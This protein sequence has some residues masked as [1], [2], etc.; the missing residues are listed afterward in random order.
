MVMVMGADYPIVKQ[1][2]LAGS[3]GAMRLPAS[4]WQVGWGTRRRVKL[5][6]FLP[7]SQRSAG[8]PISNLSASHQ[9]PT[10][11]L[12]ISQFEGGSALSDF[13][14]QQLLPA[15]QDVHDRINGIAARFV[16]L[17]ATAPG[18]QP[19]VLQRSFRHC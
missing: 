1:T 9:A 10:V 19:D 6:A 11:T 14:V 8:H 12:H 5:S 4:S 2:V 18:A 15:L 13:R 17:V 3:C 16:H 7:L